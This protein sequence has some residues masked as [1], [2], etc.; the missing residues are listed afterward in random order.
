ME[1]LTRYKSETKFS[2]DETYIYA[3]FSLSHMR[4]ETLIQYVYFPT[5]YE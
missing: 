3:Y 4:L 5:Q 2:G 1:N